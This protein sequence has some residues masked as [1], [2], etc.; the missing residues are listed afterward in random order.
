M[1][2]RGIQLCFLFLVCFT[3]PAFSD[4]SCDQC[5]DRI[6]GQCEGAPDEPLCS[7]CTANCG[8]AGD[9]NGGGGCGLASASC[10]EPSDP[11][12]CHGTR[13]LVAHGIGS[14]E[15]GGK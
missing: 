1:Q 13:C 14:C 10:G 8:G 12:C 4:F 9:G 7:L 6:W 2:S 11:P 5:E 15:S 3:I